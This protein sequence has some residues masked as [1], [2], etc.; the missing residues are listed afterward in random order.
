MVLIRNSVGKNLKFRIDLTWDMQMIQ[1]S[2]KYTA[3]FHS[4]RQSV[5]FITEKTSK[6]KITA[7]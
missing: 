1:N 5:Q 4:F 6:K 7:R 3:L 2:L